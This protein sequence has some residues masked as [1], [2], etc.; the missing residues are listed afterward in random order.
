MDNAERRFVDLESNLAFQ[1]KLVSDLNQVVIE[2]EARITKLEEKLLRLEQVLHKWVM[3]KPP[4][5][6][7]PHY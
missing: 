5:E 3:D 6:R 2:Q 1:E 7:P 4:H